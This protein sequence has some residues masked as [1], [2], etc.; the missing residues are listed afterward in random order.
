M[1]ILEMCPGIPTPKLD[2]KHTLDEW[3]EA[4]RSTKVETS[5]GICGFSQP[6]LRAMNDSLLGKLIDVTHSATEH[7][8]PPW[9]M[10]SKVVLVPKFSQ[11]TLIKDMRPITI[12][13]LIFRTWSKVCARRLLF[14]WSFHLPPCIVGALPKRSCSQLSL[15]N[16]IKIEHQIKIGNPDVGGFYL[17]ICKCFNGFG[18]LPVITA[19]VQSGF[20]RDQAQMWSKS[21]AGM[22]R[23]LD[24]LQSCSTLSPATTGLAEGDPLS[25]C[26]MVIIGNCWYRF[27]LCLG[28][29]VS[30]YADD[31]S[32]EGC[33]P[34]QHILAIKM[35]EQFLKSLKL[36]ADPSKIWVW[37]ATSKSRKQWE[38]IS[39]QVVGHP[40]AYRISMAEKELGVL[41]HYSQQNSIGHQHTRI[42]N[43]IQRLLRLKRLP[44][45]IQNKAGIVQTNVWPATLYGT[46]VTYLGKKHFERLR[47]AAT[48]AI[49]TKTKMT[50][51][52]LPMAIL[53]DSLEDP[54]VYVILRA[55][56]LW[57]RLLI[58]DPDGAG[59][60]LHILGTCE[61]NPNQAYGPACALHSYLMQ[62]NWKINSHGVFVDHLGIEFDL[63]N[64]NKQ[65]LVTRI[66]DAWD[67]VVSSSIESRR[68]FL[69]WPVPQCS[70]TFDAKNFEE[71]RKGAIVALH[72]TLGPQFGETCAKW[73]GGDQERSNVCP[74]CRQTDSRPHFIMQCEGVK[75]IRTKHSRLLHKIEQDF[76]HMLLLPI[77][78]KH[79]KHHVVQLAHHMRDLPDPFTTIVDGIDISDGMTFYADGSCVFP[80][81]PDARL[82]GFSIIVDLC[83]NDSDR[84]DQALLVRNNDQ[85]PVTL[86]PV[87]AGLQIG[88]Q[89]IN[90]AEFTAALQV[91]Q[92]CSSGCIVTDSQ[93]TFDTFRRVQDNPVAWHY[94]NDANYDL[95]V[96]LCFCFNDLGR[97][98]ENFSIKKIRAHQERR[99][100]ESNL[101]LYGVVANELA[102]KTAKRAVGENV[103]VMRQLIWEVGLFYQQ[104][105]QILRQFLDVLTDIDIRRSEAKE[106]EKS[107]SAPSL[108]YAQ[109]L[110]RVSVNTNFFD[111][112]TDVPSTVLAGFIPGPGLLQ[113]LVKWAALIRWPDT[114]CDGCLGISHYELAVNF[115]VATNSCFPRIL[116]R[117]RRYPQ[118]V[119][120]FFQADAVLL[121]ELTF[122][123]VRILEQAITILKKYS[124]I[125]L[126]PCAFKER[127]RFLGIF[128]NSKTLMGYS[129]RPELPLQDAHIDRMIELTANGSLGN[130][131]CP[132][133]GTLHSGLQRLEI[134]LDKTDYNDRLKALRRLENG[135]ASGG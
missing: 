44:I 43:G 119:D 107:E 51:T 124:N 106:R 112:I 1:E 82:A 53:H 40:K 77:L 66:R 19:L 55:L 115:C 70:L 48:D 32:W 46:D 109:D 5:R 42:D 15:S 79:P 78:Y 113:T 30:I 3:K 132:A 21:L 135:T 39:I 67:Y 87:H 14:H 120:P 88:Q 28:I 60:Y 130:P 129:L 50:N 17:D 84:I 118:F 99:D 102:D 47:S 35:T 31:W 121:P 125:D 75:D 36:V 116:E 58:T 49:L 89:T 111:V 98:A 92:S 56:Y 83:T 122:D 61:P 2:G 10:I 33:D 91:V 97:K 108:L 90:R 22:T 96:L 101:D 24:A 16:A 114:L 110:K 63:R 73:K 27:T 127:R 85:F 80:N 131:S 133:N 105:R 104:Q 57:R 11:A 93:W 13:S 26:G 8:L 25:V 100:V 54:V 4:I 59:T 68:D 123:A 34:Q 86:V 12:F 72:Q 29:C 95:I 7:G 134:P 81:I 74:L 128:G 18:R 62:L 38:M 23:S 6:E 52:L 69:N 126:F 71:S 76:P 20:P 103:S 94:Y 9:M 41:L 37:G 64:V 117:G 65:F 45:S